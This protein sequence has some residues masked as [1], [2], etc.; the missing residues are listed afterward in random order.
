MIQ[1]QQSTQPTVLLKHK[2]M[3]EYNGMHN[4]SVF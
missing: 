2:Q 4:C 1:W 3:G